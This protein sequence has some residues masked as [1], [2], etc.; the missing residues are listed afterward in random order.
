MAA[1]EDRASIDWAREMRGISSTEKLVMRLS[2]SAFLLRF[3]R[4]G[5]HEPHDDRTR[6]ELLDLLDGQG[7]CTVS[8]MS[9]VPSTSLPDDAQSTFL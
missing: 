3:P 7:S 4:I 6:L 8:T 2:R 1:C 5:L 9:D